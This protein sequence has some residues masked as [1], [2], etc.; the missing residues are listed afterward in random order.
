M[1]MVVASGKSI[2]SRRAYTMKS[3]SDM[4]SQLIG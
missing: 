3:Y 1:A 4:K 2:T